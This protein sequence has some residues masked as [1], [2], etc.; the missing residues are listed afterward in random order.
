[1]MERMEPFDAFG[2]ERPHVREPGAGM[3]KI[4]DYVRRCRGT[5]DREPAAVCWVRV[6]EEPGEA[7]VIV[8][9]ELPGNPSTSVTNMAEFWAAELVR[10]H[11]PQRFDFDPPAIVLDHYPTAHAERG[12]VGRAATWD[13][14]SFASWAPRRVWLAGR[15][16]IAFG[17][18]HREHLPAHDVE[19]LIGQKETAARPP[20][21]PATPQ[22]S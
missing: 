22:P 19:Q 2:G 14:L 3:G 20:A 5:W 4:A 1:M 11:F 18:P 13:R 7:P 10:A 8:L 16:R 17:A 15:E 9:G 21:L 6:F 12:T